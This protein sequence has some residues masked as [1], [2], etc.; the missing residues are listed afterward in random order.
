MGL[1][2]FFF[3]FGERKG[4]GKQWFRGRFLGRR[5]GKRELVTAWD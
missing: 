1:G 4:L 2:G 5:R 3:W